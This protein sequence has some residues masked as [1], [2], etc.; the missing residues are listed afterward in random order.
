MRFILIILILFLS[1]ALVSSQFPLFGFGT[2]MGWSDMPVTDPAVV[3]ATD[4]AISEKF[5]DASVTSTVLYARKRNEKGTQ[6]QITVSCK[7]EN[8]CTVQHWIVVENDGDMRILSDD[9]LLPNAC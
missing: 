3:Q 1:M 2:D 7:T 5:G 4:F 8:S 6:Y 9:V